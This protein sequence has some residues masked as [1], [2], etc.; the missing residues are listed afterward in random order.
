MK[1]PATF[2]AYHL[3]AQRLQNGIS[4]PP[5]TQLLTLA[6]K[7]PLELMEIREEQGIKLA[8]LRSESENKSYYC[9]LDQCYALDDYRIIKQKAE[10]GLFDLALSLHPTER[11][12]AI[13]K[14]IANG[15]ALAIDK[16]MQNPEKTNI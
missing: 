1:D 16:V 8:L 5:G 3:S 14:G 10:E 4:W 7:D 15:I 9:S 6:S 13:L 12:L 2:V 11:Q